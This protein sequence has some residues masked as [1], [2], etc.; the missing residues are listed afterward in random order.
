MSICQAHLLLHPCRQQFFTVNG[1]IDCMKKGSVQ[2]GLVF[3]AGFP[4][5]GEDQAEQRMSLDAV[6]FQHRLST[7][8]W[9]LEEDMSE[10]GWRAGSTVVV[11]RSLVPRQNDLVVAI[12]EESFVVRKLHQ[13]HLFDA[14]GRLDQT[15][16]ISVWGVITH[17]LQEY[18]SA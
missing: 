16:D 17:V 12:V 11:D 18:R 8:L 4:N 3:H 15:E 1:T 13:N 2:D 9:Q 7:F 6:V 14:A 5:A 10:L